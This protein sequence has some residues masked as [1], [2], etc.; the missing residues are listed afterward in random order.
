MRRILKLKNCEKVRWVVPFVL[1]QKVNKDKGDF[2]TRN[3]IK[4]YITTN[5]PAARKKC[6]GSRLIKIIMVLAYIIP[7]FS[8]FPPRVLTLQ[9][10]N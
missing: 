7:F 1:P 10:N 3:K 5:G 2:R 4:H 8:D 6:P 9:K